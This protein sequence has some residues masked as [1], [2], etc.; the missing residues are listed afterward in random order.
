MTPTLRARFTGH[1]GAVYALAPGMRPGTFLSAGSDGFVVQWDLARPDAG[2]AV[3]RVGRPV[4]ALLQSAPWLF[5][6]TDG[7][8]LIAVDL[9]SRREERVIQAQRKGLYAIRR[10]ADG[11]TACA[12]GD[13]TLAV[14]SGAERLVPERHVPLSDTKLR[15]LAVAPEGDTLAVACGDGTVRL[16]DTVDLNERHTLQAHEGGA[17]CAAFHPTKPALL[18]GGKD[19][20][21]RL[22]HHSGTVR[23]MLAIPA[24]KAAIYRVAF[25]AQ[26]RT[27]ATA[28]RDKHVKL[29][30]A[31]G[32]DVRARIDR[33]LDGHRHSVNTLLWT[34]EL[35][36][37]AGDDKQVLAWS[38]S[39]TNLDA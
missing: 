9:R 17:L 4:Y 8:D 38:L 33:T 39:N 3:V 22:W 7:G 34:D 12:A 35:L 14:Y 24:H 32:F 37:T 30:D 31:A 15:D 6:G 1:T 16:L 18:T 20:H 25:D 21:L 11:R 29:W 5:I 28:S 36:I 10:L 2:E 26:G 13:G 27:C 19:G 23:E